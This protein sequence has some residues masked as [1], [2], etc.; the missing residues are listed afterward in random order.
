MLRTA[1]RPGTL[2]WSRDDES[3]RRFFFETHVNEAEDEL[4][5]TGADANRE[6]RELL[7][8]HEI[9]V[10]LLEDGIVDP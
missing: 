2:V 7:K 6:E 5:S 9:K 10:G 1:T 3:R 4:D 8:S